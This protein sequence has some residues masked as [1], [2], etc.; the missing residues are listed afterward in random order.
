MVIRPDAIV[1][2]VND[3]MSARLIS[4]VRSSTG[5]A[6]STAEFANVLVSTWKNYSPNA[7]RRPNVFGMFKSGLIWR[8]RA[9]RS[10]NRIGNKWWG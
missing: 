5:G 2:L 9:K 6:I 8:E 3:G 4:T 1:T 10:L 7:R